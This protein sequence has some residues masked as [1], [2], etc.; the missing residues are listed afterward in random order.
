MLAIFKK[1]NNK[2]RRIFNTSIK[3]RLIKFIQISII[4]RRITFNKFARY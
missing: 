2:I 3:D 4:K 1:H